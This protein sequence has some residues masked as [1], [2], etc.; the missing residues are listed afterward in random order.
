[1]FSVAHGPEFQTSLAHL[2]ENTANDV[3]AF[4]METTR[5]R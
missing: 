1:M 4:N 5:V 2:I 3:F